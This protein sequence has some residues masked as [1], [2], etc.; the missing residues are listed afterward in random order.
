MAG[1][2]PSGDANPV[3]NIDDGLKFEW[4]EDKNGEIT[5]DEFIHYKLKGLTDPAIGRIVGVSAST[6]A[7]MT[8][9]GG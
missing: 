7:K 3:I 1:Y 6:V 4:D 5:T 9:V 8:K 2:D